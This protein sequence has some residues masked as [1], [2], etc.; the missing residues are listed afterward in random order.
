VGYGFREPNVLDEPRHVG[1][2][3]ETCERFVQTQYGNQTRRTS[4]DR[5]LKQV[6]RFQSNVHSLLCYHAVSTM[7]SALC[8]VP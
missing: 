8:T 5:L 6:A 3:L 4:S 1:R 7:A 2:Q